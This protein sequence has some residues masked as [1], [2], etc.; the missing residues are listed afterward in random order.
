MN[1]LPENKA[2]N[3][4]LVWTAVWSASSL[5]G[6]TLPIMPHEPRS[7]PLFNQVGHATT[8][9]MYRRSQQRKLI[10]LSRPALAA[11]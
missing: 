6:S 2:K 1:L 11:S 9:Q 3:S 4:D 5:T 7:F 10:H 8:R